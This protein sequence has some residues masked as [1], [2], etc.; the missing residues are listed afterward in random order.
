MGLY[1][2]EQKWQTAREQVAPGGKAIEATG[3]DTMDAMKMIQGEKSAASQ[4]RGKGRSIAGGLGRNSFK[5]GSA[6]EMGRCSQGLAEIKGRTEGTRL[7][8]ERGW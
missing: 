6:L 5:G 7:V 2:K 4:K 3:T 8:H 1:Q